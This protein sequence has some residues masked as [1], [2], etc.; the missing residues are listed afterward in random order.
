MREL[1]VLDLRD[2]PLTLE[3][4]Y[5]S[6]VSSHI[7]TLK[8]LDGLP[9]VRAAVVQPPPQSEPPSRASSTMDA[10]SRPLSRTDS[11]TKIAVKSR[12]HSV[13]QH[14][15]SRPLSA[16][17]RVVVNRANQ[18]RQERELA[19]QKLEEE[20]TAIARKRKEEFE[21]AANRPLPIPDGFIY[22]KGQAVTTEDRTAPTRL[23]TLRMYLKHPEFKERELELDEDLLA[24]RMNPLLPKKVFSRRILQK[25]VF[26]K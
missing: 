8:V 21:A 7:P 15:T 12:P 16:A 17:E 25:L 5:R 14:I 13:L 3:K 1:Q 6:F 2:N 26:P 24:M 10:Q 18:I 4:G 22:P 11:G 23:S 20:Q 19:K 9:I